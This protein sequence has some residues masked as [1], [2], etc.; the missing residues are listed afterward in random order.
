[1]NILMITQRPPYP[2]DKGEK[3]RSYRELRYL[4]ER[5]DVWCAFLVDDPADR[6]HVETIRTWCRDVA[7][8]P[9]RRPVAL[10]RGLANLLVGGTLSE[11]YFSARSLPAAL[12]RWADE[13]AFDAVLSF[14]SSIARYGL[15]VPARR[16][17]VDLCDVDSAKFAA[18]A[19][20][21][22]GPARWIFR[23]ESA[24][25]ARREWELAERHDAA[26]VIS[27]LE[28][29]RLE[30]IGMAGPPDAARPG[31]PAICVIKN[32]IDLDTFSP[33]PI[34]VTEPVI[35]F[36]GTMSYAPNVEAVCW[37]ARRIWPA[38][39]HAVP[40]ARFLIVGR[41]PTRAVR[42]LAKLSGV[43]VTGTVPDV[44]AHLRRMQVCVA[45]LQMIHGVQNKALQAMACAKPLVA[46]SP[47]ARALEAEPGRHLQV[48]DHPDAFAGQVLDLLRDANLRQSLGQAAREFV[49]ADYL[50]P[51]QL[52][53]LE[54][55][56]T[57]PE[58]MDAAQHDE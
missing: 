8:F 23:T 32:G 51:N 45:P 2:P 43:E 22:R 34:P 44:L 18:Y 49:E 37:F 9:L 48:A 4:A 15:A 27:A 16:H 47:V 21:S 13:I 14:S 57:P 36:V 42:R 41:S 30:Q 26:A 33:D 25:L 20:R 46:T 10:L 50:W 1:M 52:A 12:Q 55:V 6:Q 53:K 17:V 3:I 24:R 5:H 28:A 29:E 19:Q 31:R 11:G 56:L 58:A 40:E 54:S 7:A 35:G 39:R 38:I